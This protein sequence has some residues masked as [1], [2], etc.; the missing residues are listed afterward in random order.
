MIINPTH[1]DLLGMLDC[2]RFSSKV[3]KGRE[4]TIEHGRPSVSGLHSHLCTKSS[5][6]QRHRIA[7]QQIV[8]VAKPVFGSH[9]HL[10]LVE[11]IL[12]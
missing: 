4:Q 9:G 6:A 1:T 8:L 2:F 12:A 7:V 10:P 5:I 3:A 11:G